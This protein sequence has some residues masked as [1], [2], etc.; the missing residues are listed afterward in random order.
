M[1]SFGRAMALDETCATSGLD[2]STVSR[3]GKGSTQDDPCRIEPCSDDYRYTASVDADV[4]VPPVA[5]P[6]D[7]AERSTRWT[8]ALGLLVAGIHLRPATDGS[9]YCFEVNPFPGSHLL[10]VRGRPA[11]PALNRHAPTGGNIAYRGKRLRRRTRWNQRGFRRSRDP[12]RS[13]RGWRG[14]AVGT[15]RAD[16]D[17]DDFVPNLLRGGPGTPSCRRPC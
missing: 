9:W 10:R 12:D 3:D 16:P 14:D 13:V 5:L 4:T 11:H 6:A 15:Q 1:A 8:E 17:R 7:V 2:R